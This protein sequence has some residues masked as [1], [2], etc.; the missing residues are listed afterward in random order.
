MFADGSAWGSCRFCGA[1]V[2][3]GSPTCA[4]CGSAGPIPASGLARAPARLRRRIAATHLLRAGLVVVVVVAL[5][6]SL[7]AAVLSGPPNAA[8]PLTTSGLYHLAPGHEALLQ[9]EITGGDYVVGNFTTVRPVGTSVTLAVYNS[10]AWAS[11]LR[12]GSA[13][14]VWSPP[15][16]SD[17][18][19]VFT[20]PYTDTYTFVIANPYAPSTGFNL[21]VY[22]TTTYESNV[23][24]EGFA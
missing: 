12:N 22:V 17:G 19:I 13:S 9:G 8:D 23:G 6:Y 2:A 15:G 21:T 1:A 3:P 14:P 7:L 5:A 18:R 10:S 16:T 24:A 20:A 11:H 4:L